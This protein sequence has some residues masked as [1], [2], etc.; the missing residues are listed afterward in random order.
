MPSA[1]SVA[2]AFVDLADTLVSDFDVVEFL[3]GLT[4]RAMTLLGADAAGLMLADANGRLQVMAASS[5]DARLLELCQLQ[6]QEGP[7]LDCHRD[8]RD[9]IVTDMVAQRTDGRGSPPP[10]G[11]PATPQCTPSRCGAAAT[12]S[13]R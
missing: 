3:H 5:D 7:C 9:V 2:E 12:C 10:A 8:G 4:A 1:E 6:N 13:A 11:P